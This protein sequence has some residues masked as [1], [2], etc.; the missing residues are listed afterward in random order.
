MGLTIADYARL[1]RCYNE[2]RDEAHPGMLYDPGDTRWARWNSAAASGY[3]F[4]DLGSKGAAGTT[5][6]PS[7]SERQGF[8]QYVVM[9]EF[10]DHAKVERQIN[11]HDSL[12]DACKDC[13]LRAGMFKTQ[14]SGGL[15]IPD[16]TMLAQIGRGWTSGLMNE[17]VSMIREDVRL[18]SGDRLRA[19][20]VKNAARDRDALHAAR[21]ELDRELAL[22]RY[23][24]AERQKQIDKAQDAFLHDLTPAAANPMQGVW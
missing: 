10:S 5:L 7:V 4:K 14:T 11:R 9:R 19:Y 17:L 21:E 2:R 1:Y 15:V 20:F 12:W 22:Y 6:P 8:G 23:L 3:V 13:L 18:K 16:H 24:S